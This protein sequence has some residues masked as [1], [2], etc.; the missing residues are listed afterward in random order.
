[1]HPPS[2]SPKFFTI[3]VPFVLSKVQKN[4]QNKICQVANTGTGKQICD[5]GLQKVI[6]SIVIDKNYIQKVSERNYINT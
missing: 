5:Y 1:M 2:E 6:C 3:H 4:N